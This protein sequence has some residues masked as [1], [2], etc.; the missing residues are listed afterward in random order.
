MRRAIVLAIVATLVVA[1]GAFAHVTVTPTRAAPGADVLLTFV[2]PNEDPKV[3]IVGIVV[4]PPRAFDYEGVE[5]PP[6]WRVERRG[7][8]L[9]WSGGSVAPGSFVTFALT[10][11]AANAGTLSF[12]V[13]EIYRDG[14]EPR[15]L[16]RVVVAA[17]VATSGRD[18]GARTLGKAA[19]FVAIAAGVVAVATFFLVL[20]LW[21]RGGGDALQEKKREP[22]L[23]SDA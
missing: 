15:Y 10:G 12:P 14:R 1:P 13:H 21:L 7:H 4:R 11:S 3:P 22:V 16:P 5:G 20:A 8:E 2:V 6:G 18:S 23:R 9:A 17:P 19:L